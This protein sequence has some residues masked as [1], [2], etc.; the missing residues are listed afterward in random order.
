G[1]TTTESG[2]TTTTTSGTVETT[3]CEIVTSINFTPPKRIN[4]WSHDTRTFEQA[5]G[6]VGMKA[7]LTVKKT[8][9][10][11]DGKIVDTKN[12]T[13]D[14]TP[15]LTIEFACDGA[16]YGVASPSD[17]WKD[18]FNA[19]KDQLEA[20]SQTNIHDNVYPLNIYYDSTLAQDEVSDLFLFD[21]KVLMG[22]HEIFIAV[23]GDYTLNNT[24]DSLDAQDTLTYYLDKT[25]LQKEGIVFTTSSDGNVLIS[26]NKVLVEKYKDVLDGEDGLIFYLVNVEY[27]E[28]PLAI[29]ATDAQ[30]IL[31]YYLE[32]TVMMKDTT[33]T[34]VVG[35]DINMDSGYHWDESNSD[36]ASK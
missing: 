32:N 30:H 10:D 4:Y 14:I 9:Y 35:Y 29:T 22:I 26:G 28:D 31:R 36:R 24:V 13:L 1:T 21:D 7:E 18:E 8:F 27:E 11:A 17:I 25:V 2:T 19:R 3:R 15:Y 23:K 16:N 20:D 5:G 6:L 34:D 33:W 12:G